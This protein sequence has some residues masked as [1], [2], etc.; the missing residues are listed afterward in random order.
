MAAVLK[1][2]Q[3]RVEGLVRQS[4]AQ[5]G[6][7]LRVA[8]YNTPSQFVVSGQTRAVEYLQDLV[9]ENRGRAVPLAVSGAFHSPLI[10]GAAD[11]LARYMDRLE[12]HD[13]KFPIY[14]N[15]TAEP[16]RQARSIREI[17]AR[18]MVSSVLWT[19]GIKAQWAAGV[20]LWLELGPK[21]VLTRMAQPILKDRD[22]AWQAQAVGNLEQIRVLQDLVSNAPSGNRFQ[23]HSL[24]G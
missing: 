11:E 22:Q 18:Q 19:Q 24:Q 12:W 6:L 2:S 10:Q 8:N 14:F 4:R 23:D 17:M 5:T 9:K 13:A 3:D 21:Q 16:K 20:R 15:L 1:L 7:E